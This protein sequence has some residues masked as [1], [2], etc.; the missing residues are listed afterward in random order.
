MLEPGCITSLH[1]RMGSMGDN[2]VNPSKK[3]CINSVA[4]MSISMR[5]S[6]NSRIETIQNTP[7]NST[8]NG[9]HTS[10]EPINIVT[11]DQ[12]L[13]SPGA[14][15]RDMHKA[16]DLKMELLEVQVNIADRHPIDTLD[17]DPSEFAAILTKDRRRACELRGSLDSNH[18]IVTN[19]AKRCNSL[20]DGK[21][22][23]LGL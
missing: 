12:E 15:K 1:C 8:P 10:P 20:R 2:T 11:S 4:S 19:Q 3:G 5:V 18:K 7:L 23:S 21:L 14:Q 16:G 9:F 13:H 22:G 17:I 6:S